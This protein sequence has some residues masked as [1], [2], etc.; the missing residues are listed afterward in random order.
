MRET[1]RYN[2]VERVLEAAAELAAAGSYDPAIEL[3]ADAIRENPARL[4]LYKQQRQIGLRRVAA[5][6]PCMRLWRMRL[7]PMSLSPLDALVEA[8][9][10]ATYRPGD[11]ERVIDVLTRL[12]EFTISIG[13]PAAIE[14]EPLSIW[15]EQH[16]RNMAG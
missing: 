9:R 4:E 3:L 1:A 12:N 8:Q 13:E 14:Y 2:A 16:L 11:R 6:L 10:R 5:G 15:L 7:W